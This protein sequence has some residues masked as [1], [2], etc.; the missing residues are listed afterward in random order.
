MST[1]AVTTRDQQQQGIDNLTEMRWTPEQVAL[2]KRTVAK[3]HSDDELKMF[4]AICGRTGLDPFSRQIYSIKRGGRAQTQTSIDG[5][6]L[7]A[8]RSGAYAGQVGPFWCG[9][10]GV[11]RDAWLLDTAPA[12]ARV[13]VMRHGFAEPIYAVARFNAYS[14]GQGLW[15]KMPDVMIAKCAEALALR[16]AFPQELSGL[17]T[18]DEMQQA[19]EPVAIK[20]RP[21]L[22]RAVAEAEARQVAATSV[23]EV[24]SSVTD[25]AGTDAL[26]TEM[27]GPEKVIT[28]DPDAGDPR[29][30]A[31]KAEQLASSGTMG[32]I[33]AMTQL[34]LAAKD[35]RRFF[36]TQE[37]KGHARVAIIDEE[38]L[39]ACGSI[40][41]G[42]PVKAWLDNVNKGQ[43]WMPMCACLVKLA[44]EAG[45]D[46]V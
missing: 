38:L 32:A 2:M 8:T 13:G 46:V 35:K 24:V 5:F 43:Y 11:W 41:N 3:D 4:L 42:A 19:D 34:R 44:A 39:R 33:Q 30:D 27:Y 17:Y 9:T 37:C 14:Q 45:V 28:A 29:S 16:R 7:I 15:L 22:A 20:P 25:D 12:A 1:D 23:A 6:R 36:E 40:R 31:D 26:L 21:A 18:G 10:D